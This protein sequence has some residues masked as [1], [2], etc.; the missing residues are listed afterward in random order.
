MKKADCSIKLREYTRTQ[1]SPTLAE[2][3]LV[4][5][6]YGAVRDA[7]G[8]NCYLIGSFARFTSCRPLHD[9]DVLFVAGDFHVN[10]LNPQ[11]ILTKLRTALSQKF[12]N[13]TAYRFEISQ[14]THSI[15]ICFLK[16][17]K[18]VSP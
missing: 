7:L 10:Q 17:K 12:K 11:E 14:Q 3:D 5:R 18:S 15:T 1:V 6:L 16:A 13:P 8:E 9:I 2:K 4:T